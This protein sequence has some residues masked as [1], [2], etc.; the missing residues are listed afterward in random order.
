MTR[1]KLHELRNWLAV[2]VANVEAFAD[3]KL[4]PTPERLAAVL[5]ALNAIDL[6]IG[7]LRPVSA[8]GEP[9]G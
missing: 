6:L 7:E 3:G 5:E 2:A 4:E 9:T 1:L 8:D